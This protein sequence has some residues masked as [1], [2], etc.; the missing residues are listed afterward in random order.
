MLG[1]LFPEQT[2]FLGAH[3]I[4]RRYEPE[5][6]RNEVSVVDLMGAKL[7]QK[8][9]VSYTVNEEHLYGK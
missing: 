7:D 9:L 3:Q 8:A 6:L 4:C 1:F 2:F 5:R